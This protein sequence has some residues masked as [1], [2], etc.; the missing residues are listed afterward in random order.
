MAGVTE[1]CYKFGVRALVTYLQAERIS[2][3][4]IRRGSVSVYG[5]N[6]FRINEVYLWC[7]RLNDSDSLCGL[8]VRVRGCKPRDP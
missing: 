1:N 2:L 3:S 7:N 5:Q 8:V 6:V 4:E